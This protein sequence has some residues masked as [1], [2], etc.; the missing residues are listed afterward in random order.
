MP[1]S[2][3]LLLKHFKTQLS[4]AERSCSEEKGRWLCANKVKGTYMKRAVGMAAGVKG[5]KQLGLMG[6][7]NTSDSRR[8]V[9]KLGS[10]Q[11]FLMGGRNQKEEVAG[12]FVDVW[13]KSSSGLLFDERSHQ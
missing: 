5:A 3:T 12:T 1:K 4:D 13:F 7:L 6:K 10:G 9:A 8:Q 2:R 11:A